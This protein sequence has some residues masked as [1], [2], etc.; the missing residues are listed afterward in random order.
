MSAIDFFAGCIG[1][2]AGVLAGHPLDTVKVRLQMQNPGSKLYRGTWHCFKTIIRKE[3]FSGLYKGLSSP[4]ASLTAINAVVFGVHG[5]VC[6]EFSHPDSLRAHFF[7]GC[8][9]GMMQS[10]IA[11]PSERVKL[12]IQIQT[13]NAHSRY[14][15]PLHAA[16]S[17]VAARGFNTLSRGF[18]ATLVRDCPAFGIYFASYEWMS[19]K[20][21]KDGKMESLTGPQL[22]LA[23]GAAG[24]LSWL[25]NYPSDVVK[26]RFQAND[27]YRNYWHCIRSTY[28]EGGMRAFYTGL[29]STLLRAFPSNAA[30]F[31]AVEWTYRLLLDFKILSV[32]TPAEIRLQQHKRHICISDF[33]NM[34]CLY[35]LP[36]AGSTSIDPMIHGCRFL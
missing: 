8:A 21:S 11:T 35:F 3:G 17:L 6:R 36:E 29:G 20:M 23:G 19:R 1:G 22:L 16:R 7:A 32:G 9:A 15:S 4:L 5:S 13:D 30:T 14:Q 27:N 2:A 26:T 18:L 28:R 24:M 31:F 25:F 33:W 34:N 10:I 12:L